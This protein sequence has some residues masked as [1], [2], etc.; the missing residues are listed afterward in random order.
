MSDSI[1]A[2]PYNDRTVTMLIIR[3]KETIQVCPTRIS[4]PVNMV[5]FNNTFD[6]HD[7]ADRHRVFVACLPNIKGGT[8]AFS[9]GKF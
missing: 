9:R 5:T 1:I 4:N 6:R 3:L 8:A 2:F 7:L